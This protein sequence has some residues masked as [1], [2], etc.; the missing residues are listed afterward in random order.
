MH[1]SIPEK[2]GKPR[3][4]LRFPLVIYRGESDEARGITRDVSEYGVYF[5]TSSPLEIGE[6][7]EFKTLMPVQGETT[8]R[9]FCNGTV[10]RID[11]PD[12]AKSQSHGVAVRM[13][14]VRLFH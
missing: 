12:Y 7:V 6:A 4:R 2:R 5:Y 8:V 9:A 13:N 10:V 11:P 1:S 3:S 14:I